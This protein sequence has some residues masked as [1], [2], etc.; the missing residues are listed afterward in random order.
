MVDASHRPRAENLQL[1]T[2][3]AAYCEAR[4]VAV[5]AEPGRIEGGEDGIVDTAALE[6]MLTDAHEA[7]AFARAGVRWLA[8][9]FG[10]VHGSYGE[11]GVRLDYE[12]LEMVNREVGKEV[13]L[14]LHGTD[15]FDEAILARCVKGGVSKVNINRSVNAVWSDVV[16]G[17]GSVTEIMDK[18][19]KGMQAEVERWVKML[20]SEGKAPK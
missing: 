8:P 2:E 20:G 15:G 1:T 9:A 3:L 6:G 10:N 11:S 19:I 4:G 7:K 18:A 13:R 12:R 17:E 14:V 5:E 16:K